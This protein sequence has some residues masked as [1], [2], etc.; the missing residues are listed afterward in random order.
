MRHQVAKFAT[1]P[2]GSSCSKCEPKKTGVVDS[3]A[4]SFV[5]GDD[6]APERCSMAYMRIWYWLDLLPFP[7]WQKLWLIGRNL[8]DSGE[9]WW[10][11]QNN[12][13]DSIYETIRQT[14]LDSNS[15]PKTPDSIF[16]LNFQNSWGSGEFTYGCS[17]KKMVFYRNPCVP[18]KSAKVEPS[19]KINTIW[20]SQSGFWDYF[21]F[22]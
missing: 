1:I 22:L 21:E 2:C 4:D 9:K 15:S 20:V 6:V 11:W 12:L 19:Q 3:P 13:F 14:G 18:S 17:K 10:C 8:I 7:K 5:I 16:K